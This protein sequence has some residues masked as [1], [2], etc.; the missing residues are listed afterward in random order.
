MADH[1]TKDKNYDLV[2]T[3]YHA[4]HGLHQ[5]KQYAADAEKE[6]DDEALKFFKEVQSS[7]QDLN[8]KAEKLLSK[9][10]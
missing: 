2:S 3:L 7:Y 10:L 9:R 4:A 5:T 8:S 6:N 1:P